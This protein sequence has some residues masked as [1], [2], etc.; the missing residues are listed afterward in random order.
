M[1]SAPSCIMRAASAGVA[2]PPAEKLGTGSL[3]ALRNHA[4]QFVGSLVLLGGGVEL[5][6]GE[7]GEAAHL[8]S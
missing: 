7:H 1:A 4:D 5:L 2:M 3:P 8:A 6:L